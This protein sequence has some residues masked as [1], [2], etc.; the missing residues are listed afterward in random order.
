MPMLAIA[1][2]LAGADEMASYS[3]R[4]ELMRWTNRPEWSNDGVPSVTA[5]Q[6]VPRRV[7]VREFAL[8]PGEGMPVTPGGD[9]G[10]AY[11][12][13]HGPGHEP[14]D[15]LRAGE[16]LSALLLTAVSLGLAVA[17]I[18]DV[19]EVE[20][21]RELIRGLV[22]GSAEPYAVARCG[23]PIDQT[24]LPEAP[25]R[26]ADEVI[27][28]VGSPACCSDPSASSRSTTRAVQC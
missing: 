12:V 24:D 28:G 3:Y 25:R 14:L 15:W 2:A 22:G 16:A 26:S 5:V 18:T 4:N 6:K 13:L 27:R 10:A 23:Y 9:R 21:P 17:P 20:H 7:P 19:V 1:V 8:F 11:L